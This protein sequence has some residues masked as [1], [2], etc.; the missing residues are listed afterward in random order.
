LA[1]SNKTSENT[2][3]NALV[4]Y[5]P[6]A[7]TGQFSGSQG[8]TTASHNRFGSYFRNRV[9]PVNPD[10]SKQQAARATIASLSQGWR[11]LS[12][13]Q[14]LGWTNLG[15]QMARSDSQGQ[16]YTLTGLQAYTSINRNLLTVGGSILSTAPALTA[17]STITSLTITAT[18]A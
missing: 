14:R 12:D 8:S 1:T 11:A 16:T 2:C 9:I 4:K 6:S 17:A 18:A 3:Y 10:T 13:A 15:A 5:V 7:I